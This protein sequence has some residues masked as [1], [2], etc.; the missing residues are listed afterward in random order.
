[1]Y[2][3]A[4]PVRTGEHRGARMEPNEASGGHDVGPQMSNEAALRG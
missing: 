2:G 4:R 3:A 1:V